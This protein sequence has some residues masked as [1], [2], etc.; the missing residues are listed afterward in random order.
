ML[1]NRQFLFLCAILA[2]SVGYLVSAMSLGAPVSESGLTPSF[3]PILVG[4][5]AIVFCSILILQHLRTGPED[6]GSKAPATYTHLWVVAATFV[7]ILGFK[8]LGYFLSSSLYVFALIL[9]FSSFEKLPQKALISIA[10]VAAGY[11]M[12]QH[13]FGVRLPTLWG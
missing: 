1:L 13:L 11:A 12:F 8:P 4:S 2:V 10:I 5:A 9:L 7:Y 3:F 6:G